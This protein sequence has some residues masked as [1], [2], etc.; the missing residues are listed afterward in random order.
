MPL[1]DGT[2]GYFGDIPYIGPVEVSMLYS[3]FSSSHVHKL[4][5]GMMTSCRSLSYFMESENILAQKLSH[6]NKDIKK[7]TVFPV[8]NKL[9]SAGSIFHQEK[10]DFVEI[11]YGSSRKWK[12][13]EWREIELDISSIDM[14]LIEIIKH[15]L[16]LSNE[17]PK[18]IIMNCDLIIAQASGSFLFSILMA[19]IAS[20]YH[21]FR[22]MKEF[23]PRLSEITLALHVLDTQNGRA[24]G[25]KIH[26]YIESNL[27]LP[28]SNEPKDNSVVDYQGILENIRVVEAENFDEWVEEIR[29][30]VVDWFEELCDADEERESTKPSVIAL[31]IPDTGEKEVIKSKILDSYTSCPT[32]IVEVEDLTEEIFSLNSS[33]LLILMCSSTWLSNQM[34]SDKEKIVTNRINFRRA[35]HCGFIENQQ[36]IEEELGSTFTFFFSDLIE[37]EH[38]VLVKERSRFFPSIKEKYSSILRL[39]DIDLPDAILLLFRRFLC[40]YSPETRMPRLSIPGNLFIDKAALEKYQVVVNFIEMAGAIRVVSESDEIELS[41]M[42]RFLSFKFRYHQDYRYRKCFSILDAKVIMWG[43]ILRQSEVLIISILEEYHPHRSWIKEELE[44]FCGMHKL[45]LEKSGEIE[46]PSLVRH[47][48]TYGLERPKNFNRLHYVL[49]LPS[50]KREKLR[51]HFLEMLPTVCRGWNSDGG[52]TKVGGGETYSYPSSSLFCEITENVSVTQERPIQC[53][54]ELSYPLLVVRCILHISFHNNCVFFES[55]ED[56]HPIPI[57]CEILRSYT[58]TSIL[59]SRVVSSTG[60]WLDGVGHSL[61]LVASNESLFDI[62]RYKGGRFSTIAISGKKSKKRAR[63]TLEDENSAGKT[64]EL[65]TGKLPRNDHEKKIITEFVIL[66]KKVGV[67]KAEQLFRKKRGFGFLDSTHELYPYYLFSLKETVE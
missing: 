63:E 35:L 34:I 62:M 36:S 48:A 58:V 52:P 29:S 4:S 28:I 54:I 42:G 37:E 23:E 45:S 20:I 60:G 46:N 67:E 11:T 30:C 22:V 57:P 19:G 24:A 3:T 40:K 56:M 59:S 21:S 41:P 5:E 51:N 1:T 7:L 49:S 64:K 53:P 39:D 17:S 65:F 16:G 61:S 50:G 9:S 31:V 15:I 25:D 26:L 18:F 43:Y 38:F 27:C 55:S 14:I 32:R 44:Y 10:S 13:K 47:L 66:A 6:L 2:S 12:K 33:Q 8:F